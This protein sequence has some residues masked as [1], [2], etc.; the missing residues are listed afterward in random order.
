M[1]NKILV[2]GVSGF[3]ASHCVIELLEHGY[4]V[5]GT[6]SNLDRVPQLRAMYANHTIR[7]MK[8]SL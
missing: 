5:R 2:T 4:Q 8:L 6:V 1:S 7:L 3:I